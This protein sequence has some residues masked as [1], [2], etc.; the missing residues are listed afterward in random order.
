[1]MRSTLQVLFLIAALTSGAGAQ[2]LGIDPGSHRP[3]LHIPLREDT[4]ADTY[5]RLPYQPLRDGIRA[6]RGEFLA[7][8][9]WYT[10][11]TAFDADRPLGLVKNQVRGL[12]KIINRA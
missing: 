11:G 3:A 8:R 7:D 2:S 10:I 4:A 9:G 12:L 6:S 1:M 5:K